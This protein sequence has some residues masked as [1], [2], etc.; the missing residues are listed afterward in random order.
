MY[1]TQRRMSLLKTP[2]LNIHNQLVCKLYGGVQH[3]YC[4]YCAPF[5]DLHNLFIE[6]GPKT[7]ETVHTN[8]W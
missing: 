8:K 3:I 6:S 4:G 7:T 2:Y 1:W 5:T